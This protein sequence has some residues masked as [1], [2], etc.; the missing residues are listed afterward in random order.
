MRPM[1]VV[2]P[3]PA[4]VTAA[5]G[6]GLL[7]VACAPTELRIQAQVPD[8]VDWVALLALDA[9]GRGVGG[10][11]LLRRTP[12]AP[13][14]HLHQLEL[15][16]AVEVV[17][18]GYRD[19]D[20]AAVLPGRDD[21]AQLLLDHAIDL[22][23]PHDPVLPTPWW[24][25]RAP[26]QAG[27]GVLTDGAA[28]EL[29]VGWLPPCP[30]LL[31][32]VPDR[33]V[34]FDVAGGLY[35]PASAR[36]LDCTI[37]S[38]LDRC[39]TVHPQALRLDGRGRLD[40]AAL[41]PACQPSTPSA[42]ATLAFTCQATPMERTDLYVPPF[43]TPFTVDRISIVAPAN[44]EARLGPVVRPLI[45]YLHDVVP[46]P[47]C[48]AS[49]VVLASRRPSGRCGGDERFLSFVDGP[50][51][52]V[53]ATVS[54]AAPC[55]EHLAADPGGGGF[56]GVH[57]PPLQ[58]TR[59]D[60]A[61]RVDQTWG[62]AGGLSA[63]LLPTA[64]TL[65]TVEA[66]RPPTDLVIGSA[67][68]SPGPG[69]LWIFDTQGR[70]FLAPVPV[71]LGASTLDL[72]TLGPNSLVLGVSPTDPGQ[73]PH[74][75]FTDYGP[76]APRW[77]VL[78]AGGLILE[79]VPHFVRTVGEQVVV[80]SGRRDLD[81]VPAIRIAHFG[82]GLPEYLAEVSDWARFGSSSAAVPGPWPGTLLVPVTAEREVGTI[83]TPPPLTSLGI[84]DT[85]DPHFLPGRAELGLGP[86]S[87]AIT[88]AD[89][90]VWMTLTWA[91]ELVRIRVD[92]AQ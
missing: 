74:L 46:L 91:G 36:Q 63:E 86:V 48:P 49:V 17:A 69:E 68:A 56:Y 11:G 12:G 70:R 19:E 27:Q 71:P 64:V 13:L 7:L 21:A 9:Q 67:R 65:A 58:V 81:D 53:S 61:G 26:I 43:P 39:L 59:Y 3:R 44:P 18:V 54:V 40:P 88:D 50:N 45:G 55:L 80:G 20:L 89:L 76:G 60:C 82:L 78:E 47:G 73:E 37:L 77:A 24:S 10:T 30:Q 57:G 33:G 25:G 42:G 1:P 5:C 4:R 87:A 41:G 23:D 62:A 8:E 34:H 79:Q 2:F 32:T 83:A 66:G 29:T 6:L 90:D 22:A 84:L 51:L 72:A 75:H 85:Q 16:R 15:S 35:C 52:A 92:S 38:D 31:P 14:S 28:P